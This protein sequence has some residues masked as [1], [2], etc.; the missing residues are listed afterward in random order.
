MYIELSDKQWEAIRDYLPPV[1]MN[2]RPR[3]EDRAVIKMPM[4]C[5]S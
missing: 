3:C 5:D 4:A 1:N 2:G